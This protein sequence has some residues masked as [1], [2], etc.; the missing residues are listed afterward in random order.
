MIIGG[1]AYVD[2]CENSS[3]TGTLT[4]STII[5]CTA[6]STQSLTSPIATSSLPISEEQ[7]SKWKQEAAAGGTTTGNYILQG[8]Q[9][10][11]LGPKKI[12]G[13][14]TIQDQAKLFLTGR[15]WATGNIT[16]QNKGQIL[17]DSAAYGSQSGVILADGKIIVQ[18]SAKAQG[19]GQSG[20]YLMLLSTLDSILTGSDAILLQNRPTVDIIYA[21]KGDIHLQDSIILREVSGWGLKLQNSAK[22]IY[23][24]G[25]AD[26]SF[27]S[28]PGGSWEV[29]DWKETE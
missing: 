13:N 19:T 8:S 6:T 16:L 29:T 28:G 4:A 10:A 7:I 18:D 1:D 21:S 23:E 11:Y 3:I 14:V 12:E 15:V 22:V 27:T 2:I 25:L 26:T 24:T 9:T 17:L 20:S 5:S